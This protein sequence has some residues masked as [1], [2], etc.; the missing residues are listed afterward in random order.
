MTSHFFGSN[1]GIRKAL[2]YPQKILMMLDAIFFLCFFPPA[3]E[4]RCPIWSGMTAI[5][6]SFY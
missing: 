6:R 2:G 5:I 1:T 4:D 3:T